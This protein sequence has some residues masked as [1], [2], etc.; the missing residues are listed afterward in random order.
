MRSHLNWKSADKMVAERS[1]DRARKAAEVVAVATRRNCPVGTITRPIAQSGVYAGQKWT[2][3]DA[4]RLKKSI[5]VVEREKQGYA[6]KEFGITHGIVR[7]YAGH[8]LAYYARIVEYF[9]PYMRPAV[10]SSLGEV[11]TIIENG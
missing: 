6:F 2:S 8:Y 1:L 9:K 5:R 11:R 4:G 10:E 7:V 3:R